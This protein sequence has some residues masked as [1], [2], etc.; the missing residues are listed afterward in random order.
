MAKARIYN[1]GEILSRH[2]TGRF[3]ESSNELLTRVA[4]EVRR[5]GGKGKVTIELEVSP[6]GDRG[7]QIIPKV[8]HALPAR[9]ASASF[10][11]PNE[12]GEL[13][14]T[15]PDE[16]GDEMLRVVEQEKAGK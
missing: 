16:E 3:M 14:R 11:Y 15:A 1:I 4:S 10:Y 2:D 12:N 6:N 8:K 7:L 13:S 5:Y 9:A